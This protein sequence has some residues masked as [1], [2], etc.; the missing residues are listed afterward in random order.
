MPRITSNNRTFDARPDRI[1]LRDRVYQPKLKSLPDVYPPLDFVSGHLEPYAKKLVL[2]QGS[3]GACTG[4]GLAA[5][6]NYLLWQKNSYELTG[7]TQVSPRMLYHLARIYDEWPGED[8]DGSSCRGAMRG[9]HRH[10]VCGG[11]LWPYRNRKGNVEFISP[12]EGW[13]RDAARRPLGAYYRVNKNSISDIQA[14]ISEVGAVYASATVHDG[15][16]L[17]VTPE[18]QVIPFK[19]E[20]TGGHAFALIGYTEEGF[21]VQNSWGADWGYHG[22]AIMSFE[23]WVANGSD[24]WVAVLGAPMRVSATRSTFTNASPTEVEFGRSTWFGRGAEPDIGYQYKNRK[25]LPIS[26]D[27]A[28]LHSLVLGNNGKPINKLLY[29]E[30]AMAAVEEVCYTLP[31]TYFQALSAR[32]KCRLVIYAHGGLNDEKASI[33]RIQVLT[34]YFLENG[35]YPLF[36]SWKTGLTES[37]GGILED[38]LRN[39]FKALPEVREEG[40]LDTIKQKLKDARDRSIE[41]ACENLLVKP[42]WSEMKQNAAAAALPAGGM[43]LLEGHILALSKQ[44]DGMEIHLVG[45]SAGSIML[46]HLLSK[47]NKKHGIASISLFAPACTVAF[48]NEHYISAVK[49]GLLEVQNIH[50]DVMDDERERADSVGPYGKSLLYLVSRALETRH[51]TPLLGMEW[52]L[53]PDRAQQGQWND[54]ADVAASLVEWAAFSSQGVKLKLHSKK[55]KYVSTGASQIPLAHGSFDND[56]EV[57]TALIRRI[58]GAKIKAEVE[59]LDY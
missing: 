11:S 42:I 26:E 19:N 47:C 33:K 31:R 18:P 17:S 34:P 8:Y 43:Q 54:D 30:D 37:L 6:I 3:E 27:K 44:F 28:Y 20:T 16:F 22:F 41:V 25:L 24:A 40:I 55:R 56:V 51:K 57:I 36:I 32:T 23:D 13:A 45:H 14:A 2:D 48:A 21:I 29:V 10:G 58:R 53:K 59:N 39:I 35:I 46:G 38:S 9:W 12:K 5:T 52:A 50:I 15:W 1:D 4:F 7:L 49:R